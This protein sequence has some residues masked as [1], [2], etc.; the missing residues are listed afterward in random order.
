M[1]FKVEGIAVGAQPFQ[2][3]QIGNECLHPFQLG[4]LLFQVWPAVQFQEELQGR[5]RCFQLVRNVCQQICAALGLLLRLLPGQKQGV[6]QP[7]KGILQPGGGPVGQSAGKGHFG[8][9]QKSLRLPGEP[10]HSAVS[11]KQHG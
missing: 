8:P 7:G 11:D 6:F 1:A 4:L 2:P 10:L 3:Q 5:Q 9:I